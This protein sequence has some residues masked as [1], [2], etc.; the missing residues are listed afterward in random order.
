[1]TTVRGQTPPRRLPRLSNRNRLVL[2]RLCAAGRSRNSQDSIRRQFG[3]DPTNVVALWNNISPYKCL[4]RRLESASFSGI[5]L[6][7]LPAAD[8][9]KEVV[10]IDRHQLAPDRIAG[11]VSW[12]NRVFLN[13]SNHIVKK[14]SGKRRLNKL[15][16]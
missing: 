13:R 5:L 16:P 10:G 12:M 11:L 6:E 9:S 1:M 3:F 15:K 8:Y 4:G 2:H 14:N 7:S